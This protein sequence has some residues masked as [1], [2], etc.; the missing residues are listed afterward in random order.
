[1]LLPLTVTAKTPISAPLS[2]QTVH[3]RVVDLFRTARE[4]A[5]EHPSLD[6]QNWELAVLADAT[7]HWIRHGAATILGEYAQKQ[8]GHSTIQQTR[9]YQATAVDQHR[10]QLRTLASTNSSASPQNEESL[11]E[12]LERLEQLMD[13]VGKKDPEALNTL[14]KSHLA[15]RQEPDGTG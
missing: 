1:L 4:W 6:L 13:Q 7:G 5:I 8:L 2:Y 3:G 9:A 14:L 10:Q 12:Q 15:R 11:K